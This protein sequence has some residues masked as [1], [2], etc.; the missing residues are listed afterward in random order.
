MMRASLFEPPEGIGLIED[1]LPF[2][3]RSMVCS[4]VWCICLQCLANCCCRISE[5][6]GGLDYCSRCD[7]VHYCSRPDK[8]WPHASVDHVLD[9]CV[10]S[11]VL[12]WS[13]LLVVCC[14]SHRV[15]HVQR[16]F[17]EARK[18]MYPDVVVERE[19]VVLFMIDYQFACVLTY[20]S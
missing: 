19:Y 7:S 9:V 16:V 11:F 18:V 14:S 4:K 6:K 5:H 8:V 13:H 3:L 15:E 1:S 2:S 20:V 10:V 12:F 17:W